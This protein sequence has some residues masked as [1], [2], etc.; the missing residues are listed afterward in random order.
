MSTPP[1]DAKVHLAKGG[2]GNR[3]RCRYS[4]RPSRRIRV[5]SL[6]AFRQVDPAR[7]CTE[8]AAEAAK[9]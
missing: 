7:Q 9:P 1:S 2:S 4:S 5:V 8:C 3:S 6:D